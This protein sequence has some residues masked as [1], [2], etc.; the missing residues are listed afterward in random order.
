MFAVPLRMG[1]YDLTPHLV[2]VEHRAIWR[3][4]KRAVDGDPEGFWW[5]AF[6]DLEREQSAAEVRRLLGVLEWSPQW[7]VNDS[8]TGCLVFMLAFAKIRRCTEARRRIQAAQ[9]SVEHDWRVPN[10]PYSIEEKRRLFRMPLL[11]E[12]TSM[13]EPEPDQDRPVIDVDGFDV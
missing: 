7:I 3:S 2:F 5:R 11:P 1:Q 12:F 8:D 9:E 4:M 6:L 10:M 13:V